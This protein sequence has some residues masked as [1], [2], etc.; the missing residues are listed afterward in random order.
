MH[1]H[2]YVL[3]TYMLIYLTIDFK[4]WLLISEILM[5]AKTERN[6]IR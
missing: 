6:S 1:K 5:Y 3:Y 2:I 4:Y